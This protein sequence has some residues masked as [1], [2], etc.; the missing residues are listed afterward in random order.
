M[1]LNKDYEITNK[2]DEFLEYVSKK[3]IPIDDV[4]KTNMHQL[5][6]DI[7]EFSDIK[8][9]FK[10]IGFLLRSFQKLVILGSPGS[11]KSTLMSFLC[12]YFS[13]KNDNLLDMKRGIIPFYI[14]AK[15]YINFMEIRK[16]EGKSFSLLE[17]IIYEL[18]NRFSFRIGEIQ[19]RKQAEEILSSDKALVLIDALDEI[20]NVS[21]QKDIVSLIQ[22]FA[23]ENKDARFIISSRT[24]DYNQYSFPDNEFVHV[25]IMPLKMPI[26]KDFPPMIFCNFFLKNFY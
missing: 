3:V 15:D 13:I 9:Q 10:Y 26:V 24:L 2:N 23:D 6:K 21:K 4:S 17:Y 22:S 25:Y 16:K 12:Q 7:Y 5:S 18:M 20:I 14:E 1:V 8:L 11:G 19:L